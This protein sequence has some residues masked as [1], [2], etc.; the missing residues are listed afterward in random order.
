MHCVMSPY[1]ILPY[2]NIQ[3][4]HLSTVELAAFVYWEH[5][6]CKSVTNRQ[7]VPNRQ[8]EYNLVFINSVNN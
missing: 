8:F 1:N 6:I 3:Y 4:V 7:V 5:S 2:L